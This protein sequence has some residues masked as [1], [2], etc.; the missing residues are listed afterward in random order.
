MQNGFSDGTQVTV[1]NA[2]D[3]ENAASNTRYQVVARVSCKVS[4]GRLKSG[5]SCFHD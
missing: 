3:F 2:G 5:S 4:V 1:T